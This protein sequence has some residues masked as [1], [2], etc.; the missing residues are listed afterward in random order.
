[1]VNKQLKE[2]VRVILDINDYRKRR[3]E[4]LEKMAIRLGEKAKASGHGLTVCPFNA[5]DRRIIHIA[6]KE[7]PFIRTES[8]GEGKMKRI[9]IIPPKK[10]E[11]KF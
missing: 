2:A 3:A 7:D 10:E 5:S 4:N 1:M 9:K 6:L 8:L 11:I